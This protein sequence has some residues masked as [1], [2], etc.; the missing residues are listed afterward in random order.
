MVINRKFNCF[1]LVRRTALASAREARDL[2]GQIVEERFF[3]HAV[4]LVFSA[5]FLVHDGLRNKAVG[6][7]GGFGGDF[8]V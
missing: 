8:D 2:G 1:D 6:V 7:G 3:A 5:F 4:G